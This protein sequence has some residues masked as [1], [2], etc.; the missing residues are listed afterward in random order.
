MQEKAKLLDDNIHSKELFEEAYKD[1][2]WRYY[3]GLLTNC[4]T[5]GEPGKILDLG[6]GL[7]FFV[8]CCTRY[9]IEC[10]GLEGSE[11]A[12]NAANNRYQMDIR[13]HYLSQKLPFNDNTFSIV[14][15]NQ[16]IE[17]LK[18][19]VAEFMIKEAFRVLKNKGIIIINSPAITNPQSKDDTHI[20]L[21]SPKRLRQ[22]LENAGFTDI[23]S[24][25]VINRYG[26]IPKRMTKFLSVMLI[27][28]CHLEFLSATAHC[29]GKKNNSI[30]K[31]AI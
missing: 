18:K 24:Q 11:Y 21:Y 15:C 4:I 16:T 28:R 19:E 7:G 1:R 5:Y 20:N 26:F 6:A 9:G 30:F 29:I 27:R 13:Q 31:E 12:T 2:D 23:I 10:I 25:D 14:V 8:E 3:K 22:E 17:H